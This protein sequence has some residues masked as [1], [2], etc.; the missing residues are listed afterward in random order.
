MINDDWG[1]SQRV[2]NPQILAFSSVNSAGEPLYRLATQ[3]ENGNTSLI[4]TTYQRNSSVFDIWQAQL[5]L[6]YIFGR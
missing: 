3:T 6:R 2:T 5:G 4:K 1:V